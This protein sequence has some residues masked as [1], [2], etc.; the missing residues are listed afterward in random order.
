[1][2][3][4]RPSLPFWNRPNVNRSEEG[5]KKATRLPLEVEQICG[6]RSPC[7]CDSLAFVV[8]F[9]ISGTALGSPYWAVLPTPGSPPRGSCCLCSRASSVLFS[10]P[11]PSVPI[12]CFLP[13]RAA[14][15]AGSAAVSLPWPLRMA[16]T[17]SRDPPD[18]AI[19]LF[20]LLADQ[21]PLSERAPASQNTLQSFCASTASA[22]IASSISM[23]AVTS[24]SPEPSAIRALITSYWP[25]AYAD[26]EGT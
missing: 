5:L 2:R 13:R 22:C 18:R 15:L 7:P 9:S 1:M 21:Q 10:H 8:V 12:R 25:S 6:K 4:W 16:R 26:R 3:N 23:A 19:S 14:L 20:L 24:I 17:P 11:C